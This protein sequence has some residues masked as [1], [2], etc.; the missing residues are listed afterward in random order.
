MVRDLVVK[1]RCEILGREDS[2]VR[3]HLRREVPEG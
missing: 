1:Y 3:T 2:V